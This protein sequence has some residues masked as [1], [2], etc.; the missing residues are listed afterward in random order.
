MKNTK[1]LMSFILFANA[2]AIT[3][4]AQSYSIDW[5]KVAGG[6]GVSTGGVYSVSGT[7]GQPDAGSLSGN[8][9]ALQ[10]GFWAL[11]TVQTPGAPSLSLSLSSSNTVV[12]SWPLPVG[13]WRLQSTANLAATP[14]V[15][16]EIPPPYQTNLTSVFYTEPV[17]AGNRFYRLHQ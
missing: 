6:G 16:A 14:V 3:M 5:F 4:Q 2:F 12:V 9:Y 17:A 10:G 7:I 11:Y 15:W 1:L 8:N 13:S